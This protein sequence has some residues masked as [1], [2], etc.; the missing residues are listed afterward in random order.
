MVDDE[1]EEE[2][3]K[4]EEEEEEEDKGVVEEKTADDD[5]DGY[6]E[7]RGELYVTD[8]CTVVVTVNGDSGRNVGKNGSVGDKY[9][10]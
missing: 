10:R 3:E 1:Q 9:V 7:E 8:E 4:E 6:T 5:D 2:E